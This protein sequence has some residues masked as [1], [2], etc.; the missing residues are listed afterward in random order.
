MKHLI[1]II[2]LLNIFS[3]HAMD[4]E[5]HIIQNSDYEETVDTESSTFKPP[6]PKRAATTVGSY[7][8]NPNTLPKHGS[9][10]APE[11]DSINPSP[12]IST[13]GQLKELKKS[14]KNKPSPRNLEIDP[15][16][17]AS[18]AYIITHKKDPDETLPAF[19]D[20]T[21]KLAV[22]KATKPNKYKDIRK[23]CNINE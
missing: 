1:Q 23:V 10:S 2:I 5:D 3:L 7:T 12:R 19:K 15:A 22:L 20:L 13:L 17:A 9:Q 6:K 8:S 18:V 11:L 14:N 16:V 4:K 21:E